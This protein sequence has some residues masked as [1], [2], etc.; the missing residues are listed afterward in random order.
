MPPQNQD[1]SSS[2]Y[3]KR[4][5]PVPPPP[6]PMTPPVSVPTPP[7]VA[8]TPPP[9]TPPPFVTPPP[10]SQPPIYKGSSKSHIRWIV[11]FLIIIVGG[12]V[13]YA[14]QSG[15]ISLGNTPYTKE[16]LSSDIF[17]GIGKIRQSSYALHL[18][19][20]SEPK[21]ADAQPFSVAV[22]KNP[23]LEEAYKR[24]QDRVRDLSTIATAIETSYYKARTYPQSLS[25]LD[26]KTQTAAKNITYAP[27][28]DSTDYTL[29]V[30]LETTDATDSFVRMAKSNSGVKVTGKTVTVSRAGGT[31]FYTSESTKPPA[32]VSIFNLQSYLA[33]I[34]GNLKLDGTITGA[35]QKT[36]DNKINSKVHIDGTVDL[37]DINMGMDAEFRKVADNYYVI[38][39]KF[40]S[41]IADLTK[42][43]GKWIKITADEALSYGG[44]YMGIVSQSGTDTVAKSKAEAAE[45]LSLFL[46]VAD[47]DQVLTFVNSRKDT[48]DGASLTRYELEFNKAA[49]P[50]FY[51]DLVNEFANKFPDRPI[52]TLDQ[53]TLDYL[54]S[55][56]FDQ[57]FEYF[58]KNTTL[59]L[60]SDADGIPIQL[61]YGLRMVPESKTGTPDRQIRLTLTLTLKDVNKSINIEAPGDTMTIEDATIAMTGQTKEEYRFAKQLSAISTLTYALSDYK[62]LAGSYPTS[63]NDLK[64]TRKEISALNPT[65]SKTLV[66]GYND[67][68][69]V[70]KAVPVDIYTG[71]PFTY[72]KTATDY[73]LVYTIELP[74]YKTGT[75][76]SGVYTTDYGSYSSTVRKLVWRVVNGK[77]TAT[78]KST[79][80]EATA[81]SQ[82]DS[83]GDGVP[84]TLETYLG[85]SPSK[86]DTDGDGRTDS[87]ELN[88]GTNPTGAG[89]LKRTGSSLY[90]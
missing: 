71:A 20:A 4:S 56:E 25:S 7:P 16:T 57:A 77:N 68:S 51:Q 65:P 76:G 47:K 72:S 15:I 89:T 6:P 49:F 40:P 62:N 8:P 86:K 36:D 14:F 21:E 78:S 38:L 26:Q 11:V 45:Q 32:L 74:A 46:K 2:L 35:S 73:A 31:Y 53:S 54:K 3:P 85:T 28:A 1:L 5:A 9:V 41:P 48:V 55:P 81:Q 42:I 63:L 43:K 30:T 64:K 22:P 33:Y 67:S 80:Q 70:L 87:E 75:T 17:K 29:T 19:V 83:D 37:S 84:D 66:F 39:N 59:T 27:N 44:S 60:W 61:Q 88:A 79:S 58:R 50:Q 18:T 34:P 13:T 52:L 90:Y 23:A 24:D 12:G 10:V 69:P 82:K